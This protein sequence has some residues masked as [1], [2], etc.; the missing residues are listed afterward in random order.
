M[1]RTLD[2]SSSNVT[3]GGLRTV[4]S[5]SLRPAQIQTHDFVGCVRN[6]HVNGLLLGPSTALA[7]HNILDR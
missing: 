6:V 3:I 2:V 5:V 4:E 1:I 7:A